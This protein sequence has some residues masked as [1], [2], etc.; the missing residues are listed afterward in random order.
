MSIIPRDQRES[1]LEILCNIEDSGDIER[2]FV[3]E[4]A[5][6]IRKICR[7]DLPHSHEHQL[8]I[9]MSREEHRQQFAAVFAANFIPV[10]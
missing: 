9:W 1:D 7:F 3:V 8:M 2:I 4:I 6:S 10:L 5:E